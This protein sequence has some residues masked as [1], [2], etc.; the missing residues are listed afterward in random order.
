MGGM[1]AGILLSS[2]GPPMQRPH[3]P[4]EEVIRFGPWAECRSAGV[5]RNCGEWRCGCGPRPVPGRSGQ[6]GPW[7]GGIPTRAASPCAATGG[8]VAVRR[9]AAWARWVAAA[10]PANRDCD[11]SGGA[12]GGVPVCRGLAQLRRVAMRVRTATAP[13]SQ[14]AGRAEWWGYSDARRVPMCCDRGTGRGPAARRLGE[15]GCG[16]DAGQKIFGR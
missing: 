7:G 3:R 12:V 5:W 9:H 4:D 13:R 2:K 10:R 6:A 14:R 16:S 8:P 11:C 15:V 1:V